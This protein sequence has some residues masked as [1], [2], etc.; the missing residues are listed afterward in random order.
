MKEPW[1]FIFP[2]DCLYFPLD[3]RET[4]Q[5]VDKFHSQRRRRKK[6][7]KNIRRKKVEERKKR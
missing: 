4:K 5:Q 7:K 6:K 2:L 3:S 1:S